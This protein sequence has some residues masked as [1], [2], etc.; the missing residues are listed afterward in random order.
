MRKTHEDK[1]AEAEAIL[2]EDHSER[3]AS[4]QRFKKSPDPDPPITFRASA[5][6]RQKLDEIAR[7]QHRTRGN[8]IQH[9]LWT[10]IHERAEK[11]KD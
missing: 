11:P 9:I 10:Y 6:L 5:P 8:L 1:I 3:I 2:A 4:A 7:T